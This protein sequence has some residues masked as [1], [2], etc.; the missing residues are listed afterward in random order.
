MCCRVVSRAK[1][2]VL[3]EIIKKV[4]FELLSK[5]IHAVS[6]QEHTYFVMHVKSHTDLSGL[7]SCSH[8]VKLSRLPDIFQQAKLSH[9]MFHQNAPG[10]VN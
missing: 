5:L 6:H 7:I 8:S 2:A 9:Q 4:L 3:K 10:L 1:N